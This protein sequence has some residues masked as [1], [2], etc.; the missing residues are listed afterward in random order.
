[1]PQKQYDVIVV[2][3]GHAGCE[4]ALAAARMGA[5]T[6]LLTM[7]MDLVA[8]MPCNPSIGG[9]GKGHLVREID[10][11]GGEMGRNTDR[12]FIQIR[13]LNS[14][15]GPAVRALRA[16]AD[17]RLYSLAM[18]H[19]LERTPNLDLAQALT[20]RLLVRDDHVQGVITAVGQEYRGRT[21]VLTTGTFLNGRI[22][23]GEHSYPAGRAGEFP[24]VGLSSCLTELGFTLGRL[25]TNTPPRVDARTID[26]R[27]TEPQYGSETPLYFSF[28]SRAD[29]DP[30]VVDA[31]AWLNPVYLV[32]RQ[33][34]WRRQ[35]PCYLV[36]TNQ[37]THRVVRENLDRSPIA[38]GFIAG[39]GP[40]YCPS[41]EEKIT[42]FPDK[43]GH[44]FFLEPEGLA[45]GEVYVQGCF[46][47]LPEDVQL[48]MLHTIPALAEARIMRAG[49]AIEYDFCP[50][51]QIS[52]S[53]ETRRVEGLFHAGQINGTSG[54]EEAA[55][56]GLLAGIN[57]ARKVQGR[58]PVL[59]RRDQAYL[60]V[61][62]DDIVTKEITEP[63]RILTSRAEHRLLLRHDNADLRL[64]PLGHELG[65]INAA[66]YGRLEQKREQVMAELQR[67]E[68]TW[69]P[70]SS[71]VNAV[72]A[73][74]GVP[75]LNKDVNALQLL[76]R[77]AVSYEVIAALSPDQASPEKPGQPRQETR[78]AVA[79][80]ARDAERGVSASSARSACLL[81]EAIEE[82]EIEAKYRGYIAKEQV[83]VERLRRLE[84]WRIPPQTD[85]ASMGGLRKEAAE[86]LARFRPA[87][88]G[89]A[90]RIEGVNPADISI[91]LIHLRRA[92]GS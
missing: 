70:P 30:L 66:R 29:A 71:E 84:E 85:Y 5:S 88:V 3:A 65:L 47:S 43:A 22:L 34:Q 20:E 44:Q 83:E 40:R 82:I 77:P 13:M 67:L 18:K 15:R 16:Q 27:H 49:Y 4:A 42:R 87:T 25:Q 10:A 19:T 39:V 6:L 48:A 64:S 28:E 38:A 75:A 32:P 33:S 69:L 78:D 45:T 54:Y 51:T 63:Y 37:D 61:L 35:L 24:A 86:K 56:Q 80:A 74:F 14:S 9:P 92:A 41:I 90:A 53:L 76:C 12:T 11:L 1:M 81:P 62:V 7:N 26:F 52:A 59:L 72:L 91:L 17:K 73:R 79:K 23:T 50:P 21:V 2:G 46:T 57:A 89:Q 68:N 36:Y 31:E 58:A 55:A 60:G 8:Q